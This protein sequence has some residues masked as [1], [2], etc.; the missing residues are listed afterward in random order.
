[1]ILYHGS[2]V[3]IDRIDLSKSNIVKIPQEAMT[4]ESFMI[5]EMTKEMVMLLMKDRCISMEEAVNIVYTS[6][7]FSK[8]CNLSTGLYFQSTPY[9]NQYLENE[10]INGKLKE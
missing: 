2:N 5:E 4:K 8:L 10:L 7:N 1:M 6:E 9:V 3:K